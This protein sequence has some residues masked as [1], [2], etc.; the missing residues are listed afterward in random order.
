MGFGFGGNGKPSAVNI[1]GG[2][3]KPSAVNMSEIVSVRMG[4][5][6]GGNDLLYQL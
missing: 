6:F 2:N 1:V 4:F 5:G 3:A